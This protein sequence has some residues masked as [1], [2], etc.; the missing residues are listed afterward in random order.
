MERGAP[1]LW[2]GVDHNSAHPRSSFKGEDP[3]SHPCPNPPDSSQTHVTA[4]TDTRPSQCDN[5]R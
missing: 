4:I 1:S 2:P 5:D 3:P